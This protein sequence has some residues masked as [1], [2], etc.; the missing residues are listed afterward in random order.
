MSKPSK[1]QVSAEPRAERVG[2]CAEVWRAAR[3]E[4]AF[5]EEPEESS[6]QRTGPRLERRFTVAR[7]LRGAYRYQDQWASVLEYSAGATRGGVSYGLTVPDVLADLTGREVVWTSH[8]E[9]AGCFSSEGE[10]PELLAGDMLRDAQGHL[11]VL[12]IPSAPTLPD[13][14]VSLPPG[15][16]PGLRV[17][18]EEA[19]C[20]AVPG[21]RT[22][23][24]RLRFE[25]PRAPGAAASVAVGET[26]HFTWEGARY[27]VRVVRARADVGDRCGQAVFHL[28]RE[29]V[30]VQL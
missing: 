23:G 2:P 21:A 12:T 11:L 20:G 7:Q 28:F 26:G 3:V 29:G 14:E 18:W 13:G 5:K 8:R 25:D 30:R 10:H 17:R 27:E 22:R 6:R 9:A 19:G 1:R 24:V 16:V 15:L 4:V